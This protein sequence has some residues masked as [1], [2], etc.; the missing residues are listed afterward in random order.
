MSDLPNLTPQQVAQLIPRASDIEPAGRGGQKV[1]FRGVIG[2]EQY[3]LKFAKVPELSE[4]LE[5]EEV[6]MENVEARARRE[7]DIMKDC[8]SRHMVKLGSIGL[9]FAT[10]ADQRLL[11]FSEEFIAGRDLWVI[12]RSDGRF[13]PDQIVRLGLHIVDAIQAIWEIGKIHR[14]IKPGNIMRRESSNE[15]V[16]LDAGFAFDVVGESLSIGLVGTPLYYSPEQFDFNSRRTLD[17]RS[18]IFSLGVT[19]YQLATGKHPF[20]SPGDTSRSLFNKITTHVP[21]APS[22]CVADFPEE[23][24]EI[25]LRMLAKSP[26]LRYRR[27]R[28]LL[29][30]LNQV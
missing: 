5:S 15:Y 1:V 13:P 30:A 27:C 17:F 24:D 4:D 9:S 14:D 22:A 7:V 12:L 19:M 8:G 29:D 20:F 18:D 25:I 6:S 16:L 21:E 11:Y 2:G 26:H 3:A 28:H 23:L 10:I